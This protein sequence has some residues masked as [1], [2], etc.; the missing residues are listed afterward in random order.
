MKMKEVISIGEQV[1]IKFND[2]GFCVITEGDL[3]NFANKVADQQK[4]ALK[5]KIKELMRFESLLRHSAA[6]LLQYP[7]N[8]IKALDELKK[9]IED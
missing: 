5:E 8:Y 2:N 3:Q 7:D 1:D 9:E 6:D 4:Q